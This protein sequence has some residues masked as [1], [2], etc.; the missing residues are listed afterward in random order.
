MALET[1]SQATLP[2]EEL[3]AIL[4]QIESELYRTKVYRTA[5]GILKQRLGESA[6]GS[7]MLLQ[8]VAKKAIWLTLKQWISPVQDEPEPLNETE[9]VVDDLDLSPRS[10][11]RQESQAL[12]EIRTP[13]SH[14]PSLGDSD[15]AAIAKTT[16]TPLLPK[17]RINPFHRHKKQQQAQQQAQIIAHQQQWADLL[18]QIGQQLQAARCDRGLSILE[19]HKQTLVPC[20]HI[21]A[22]ENGCLS[23]LP[24]DV[25]VR[26]F[27][28]KIGDVLGLDG[29]RMANFLP[30]PPKQNAP[31]PSWHHQDF[32][33][34]FSVSPLHLYV[35]YTALM[36]GAIGGLGWMNE[37]SA[38]TSVPELEPTLTAP[39]R[40][41][42]QGLLPMQTPGITS[43]AIAC[44][45]SEI[46]PPEALEW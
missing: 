16:S 14:S 17:A 37:Q 42:R 34:E 36:A 21:E 40:D 13:E 10:S 9:L 19:L 20:R 4:T 26:S 33:L 45:V 38:S 43:Q 1:I 27:I 11:D 28:H 30:V 22:I 41:S 23:K 29:A 35:G 31:I 2:Q 18:G 8:A 6:D 5:L 12:E 24:E 46:A 25:Y 44:A 3:T 39:A 15:P 7:S 32:N